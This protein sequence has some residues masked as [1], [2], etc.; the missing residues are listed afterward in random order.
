MKKSVNLK[1]EAQHLVNLHK[2]I[3]AIRERKDSNKKAWVDALMNDDDIY[4][5]LL[6]RVGDAFDLAQHSTLKNKDIYRI[7]R[8][9][10]FH[11]EHPK[12]AESDHYQPGVGS[13]TP[14]SCWENY[15]KD[16][17][18]IDQLYDQLDDVYKGTSQLS[19][20]YRE[21]LTSEYGSADEPPRKTNYS[22][23][24]LIDDMAAKTKLDTIFMGAILYL[25]HSAGQVYTC[26]YYYKMMR[27]I[28]NLDRHKFLS[29]I[30]E[31]KTRNV[32]KYSGRQTHILL[33]DELFGFSSA[34]DFSQNPEFNIEEI[35]EELGS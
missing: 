1:A 22:H 3:N 24:A 8:N 31:L 18:L 4:Q 7:E 15:I 35:L 9:T 11:T 34:Q 10:I 21:E 27:K 17:A 12:N 25:F 32:L 2:C 23:H 14:E 28:R 29:L 6:K 16:G 19:I 26:R 30:G 33:I 5:A 13:L 20:H